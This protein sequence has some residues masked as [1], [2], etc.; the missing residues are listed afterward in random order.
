MT[1]MLSRSPLVLGLLAGCGLALPAAAA[2]IAVLP[3][4][5]DA[6]LAEAAFGLESVVRKEVE[7]VAD[8]TLASREETV[9]TLAGAKSIGIDCTA[10]A[11]ACLKQVG[12]LAEAKSLVSSAIKTVSVGS[13]VLFV[14]VVDVAS[15][16]FTG[17][18]EGPV[19]LEMAKRQ[20][21]VRALVRKAFGLPPDEVSA[22]EGQDPT[23]TTTTGPT[24][25][26]SPTETTEVIEPPAAE[27]PPET[28]DATP[29]VFLSLGGVGAGL[30]AIAAAVAIGTYGYGFLGAGGEGAFRDKVSSAD[31]YSTVTVLAGGLGVVL[32]AVGV[33]SLAVGGGLFA[34]GLAE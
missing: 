7:L 23:T 14:G 21:D 11:A 22:V 2:D 24:D 32:L 20:R 5:A 1:R 31:V 26:A 33:V 27:Q 15:G 3:L 25:P 30:G 9:A 10:T 6:E 12:E 4:K 16:T 8:G 17:Q 19:N 18:A 34:V 28:M 29:L 13:V